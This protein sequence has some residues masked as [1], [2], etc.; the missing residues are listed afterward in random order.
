MRVEGV[1]LTLPAG[2]FRSRHRASDDGSEKTTVKTSTGTAPGNVM[3]KTRACSPAGRGRA[4]LH[5]PVQPQFA[6]QKVHR[7]RRVWQFHS[8]QFDAAKRGIIGDILTD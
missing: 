1:S 5:H 7:A 2:P 4:S 6:V 8:G 3:S